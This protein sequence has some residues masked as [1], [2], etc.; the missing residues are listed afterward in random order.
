MDAENKT[1]LKGLP[2][3]LVSWFVGGIGLTLGYKFTLWILGILH[4]G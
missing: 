3:G 2:M 4:I 1:T